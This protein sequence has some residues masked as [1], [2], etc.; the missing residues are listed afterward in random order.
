LAPG[1]EL[2]LNFDPR[3]LVFEFV[4]NILL[5]G[6]QVKTVEDFMQSLAD[7]KSKVK[8]M[9]MGAGKTTVVAPLLALMLA[10]GKSLVLSVVPKALVEMSRTRMRETFATIMVKRIYTLDFDR[11]TTVRPAMRRSLANAASNRGV[12]I[13]TPT[14]VKSVMLS[15]IECLELLSEA[16]EQRVQQPAKMAELSI[17]ARELK[18]ILQMFQDGVMLM[19]EVDLILHPLKSEL[20]FPVGEKFD[21]DGSE[22]GERWDLPIH[23]MDALFFAMTGKASAFEQ[24]SKGVALTILKQVAA[25]IEAGVKARHLQRLPHVTLLNRDYYHQA[26]K[27]LM[28]EWAFLWLQKQHLHGIERDEAVQYMLEGGAAR[29]EVT[30]ALHLVELALAKVK[31]QLGDDAHEHEP[32]PTAG[33]LRSLT[34]EQKSARQLQVVTLRRQ[35]SDEVEADAKLKA[36]LE[37]SVRELE[38]AR[39]STAEQRQRVNAIYELEDEVEA[40]LRDSSAA[41]TELTR[42]IHES[43]RRI[44]ELECPRDDSFDNSVVV[45]C[46]EAFAPPKKDKEKG[47]KSRGNPFGGNDSDDEGEAEK[48]QAVPGMVSKLEEA[49]YTVRRCESWEEAVERSRELQ[50]K[51]QLRLVIGGGGESGAESGGG[52]RKAPKSGFGQALLGAVVQTASQKE[53]AKKLIKMMHTLTDKNSLYAR[54]PGFKPVP[55]ERACVF[56]GHTMLTEEQRMSLWG[57]KTSVL[58]EAR[59][60]LT[61]AEGQPDWPVNDDGEEDVEEEVGMKKQAEKVLKPFVDQRVRGLMLAEASEEGGAG[62]S[63]PRRGSK[64]VRVLLEADAL[65]EKVLLR[66]VAEATVADLEIMQNEVEKDVKAKRA[67]M[68]SSKRGDAGGSAMLNAR[69]ASLLQ[70]IR[71]GRAAG[72]SAVSGMGKPMLKRQESAGTLELKSL[73]LDLEELEAIKASAVLGEEERRKGMRGKVVQQ[74]KKLVESIDLRL[75][76][77]QAAIKQPKEILTA[78]IAKEEALA[79]AAADSKRGD[80]ADEESEVVVLKRSGANSS[81]DCALALASLSTLDLTNTTEFL[82]TER[83]QVAKWVAAVE[84]EVRSLKQMGLA[85]KVMAHVASPTHKKLLNLCH[86][87]LK[88]FMPHCLA[89]V[90]RVS[91]GLLS[92]ADCD[93]AL[94]EDPHVP[95]SRLKLAVPFVGKD[96][97]SA[98]SEFAHP[99]V[100]IGMTVLAY[101]YSGLRREDFHDVI[102]G[103][104]SQFAHEIGPARGRESS[105]RYERWVVESGGMIRG[106]KKLMKELEEE[107]NK[108]EEKSVGAAAVVSEA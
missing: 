13:A 91:F 64:A 35:R 47:N 72:S 42:R 17:Q 73:K 12:V 84:E 86:D 63:N 14:T 68:S 60:L 108:Q 104:V 48:E 32:T 82:G 74:H 56:A 6:M 67:D 33:L 26:L 22:Q 106:L 24:S 89:K 69:V 83:H 98:S 31:V 28:A 107:E 90:N 7:G 79:S 20:N 78:T 81:R 21:L 58:E 99:D 70:I 9:I 95:R 16:K 25:V 93:K 2:E 85:A 57:L 92:E 51:G 1:E 52:R 100:I 29:S 3:F 65:G 103:L 105:V 59:H 77:L 18:Q 39:V 30:T 43:Q 45:W 96:V 55:P 87:W 102:D 41:V 34:A 19:D 54:Q 10:D 88:T 75:G 80:D 97:P 66:L 4:W 5:R 15:Y 49:G 44:E 23:L 62:A 46:S 71:N 101:R 36:K 8:Q 11:S 37:A 53:G 50:Q 27:P 76:V 40:A 61:W 94:A 38:G